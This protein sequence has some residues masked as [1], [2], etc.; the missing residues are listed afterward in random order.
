M[1][2]I[3]TPDKYY[4]FKENSLVLVF[5]DNI[6]L[7]CIKFTNETNKNITNDLISDTNILIYILYLKLWAVYEEE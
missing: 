2:T 1:N 3:I 6:K 7:C 4:H 5:S